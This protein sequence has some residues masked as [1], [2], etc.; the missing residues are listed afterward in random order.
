MAEQQLLTLLEF[1]DRT[2]G[3]DSIE[4]IVETGARDCSETA[5]F[6]RRL[7]DASIYAFECNPSTLP[8]CRSVV[9]NLSNATLIEKAVSD[10]DGV[11]PFYPIDQNLTDTEW[12]DGNPGASSLFKASGK[13]PLEHYVQN[14]IM[15]NATTLGTFLKERRIPHVDLLWMDIQG[16]ELMAL[17][18]LGEQ[19]QNVKVIHTELEFFEI[20]SGQP[21]FADIKR[22][23]NRRGFR[24]AAFTSLGPYSADAIFLNAAVATNLSQRLGLY[25]REILLRAIGHQQQ[26]RQK[27]KRAV[28]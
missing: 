4:T 28:R 25:A 10:Q 14:E 24:L 6:S 26:L 8:V 15:V 13:Y 3:L 1:V 27:V 5:E 16:A 22:F 11:M 2:L 9:E 18:G 12:A 23:L 7:P 19:L 21:L 20:Y 17:K